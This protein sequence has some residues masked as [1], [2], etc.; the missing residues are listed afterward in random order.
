M[1]VFRWK[2]ALIACA[3]LLGGVADARATEWL[4]FYT[5]TG[6]VSFGVES[7]WIE[8][9]S[10]TSTWANEFEERLLLSLGGYSVDPR[11]F[12]FFLDLEPT[13]TQKRVD[14]DTSAIRVDSMD[15]T[16][17]NY[18]ARFSLLHGA[19]ASPVSLTAEF[20]ADTDRTESSLGNNSNYTIVNSGGTLYWKF[21]PF[22]STISYSEKTLEDV[23]FSRFGAPPKIRDEYQRTLNYRGKSRGMELLLDNTEFNDRTGTNND[24]EFNQAR[25]TNKF[26]WG[27]K[28]GLASRLEYLNREGFNAQESV[29]VNETLN[30]QH[31]MNLRTT[32]DYTHRSLNRTTDTELNSGTFQLNHQLY[33]NL[34]TRF[35]LYGAATRSD[36][37]QEDRYQSSLDFNYTKQFRPDLRLTAHL[38][39]GYNTYDRIGGQLD[40]TE[41]PT[42]PLSG[43]VVL[44]QRYIIWSTIVVTAPGCNPCVDGTDYVV[45]DAGGDFTQLS[46]P[47]VGSSINFLDTLTVDY[48]YEPPTAELYGIPFRVGF[49]L[50]Y[51]PFAF[52]LRTV[53]ENR[54]YVSG[55]DP[56]AV[57][58]QRTDTMGV[59]W[60]RVWNRYE[61]SAS[62]ERIYTESGG[63]AN[64]DYLLRQGLNYAIAPNAELRATLR[65][66]FIRGAT[67]VN[68]Y[69]G[70][71]AI[72]WFPVPGV[73]VQPRLSTFHRTK[74]PGGIDNYLK[75]GVDLASKWRRLAID[76]RYDHVVQ[77]TSGSGYIEDSIYLK[78]TRKF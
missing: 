28:S 24:Y 41:S 1:L 55:P 18:A 15:G 3:V 22:P 71:F 14:L 43:I 61:A 48:A 54:T 31:T 27:K 70:D 63:L 65:E 69:F 4:N 40:F 8:R 35:K 44:A 49:R 25:L 12:T 66:E 2:S 38:G 32:Y 68:A 78:L 75:A 21:R 59:E 17:L 36:E 53:G 72:R 56:T 50:D 39:S 37:F 76:F 47:A 6:E 9:E 51:G 64:T 60:N 29:W 52:Y 11:L 62:A 7:H 19:P 26:N 34:D 33:T 30:L 16:V 46:I 67:D 5:Y 23:V 10:G 58:D 73:L 42:V 77:D 74:D 57:T 20:S 13:L 45:Q